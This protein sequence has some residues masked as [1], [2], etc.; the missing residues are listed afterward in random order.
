MKR[1]LEIVDLGGTVAFWTGWGIGPEDGMRITLINNHHIDRTNRES[2]NPFPFI[3]D[4]LA[5]ATALS[6]DDFR[7]YYLVFSNSFLEHLESPSAQ[8]RLAG[9]IVE[10]GTPY[11]T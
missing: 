9:A 10:S 1:P 6:K 7:G 3:T 8:A 4:R 2:A 5:D 11:F